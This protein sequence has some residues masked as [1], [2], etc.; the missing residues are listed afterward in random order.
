MEI[1]HQLEEL[2]EEV[3]HK[4]EFKKNSRRRNLEKA[5]DFFG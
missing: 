2:W 1:N 5:I 3:D 4:K